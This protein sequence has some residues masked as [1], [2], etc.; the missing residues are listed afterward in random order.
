MSRKKQKVQQTHKIEL[1][2]LIEKLTDAG[3]F[4]A[5]AQL[6]KKREGD[7]QQQA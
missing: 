5:A 2:E 1:S 4:E 7:A 6:A 3:E